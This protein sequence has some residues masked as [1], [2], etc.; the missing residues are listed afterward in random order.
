MAESFDDFELGVSI[1]GA[2]AAIGAS[3]VISALKAIQAAS[4][5][6]ARIMEQEL[7]QKAAAR[8]AASA[9]RVASAQ[10]RAAR[11]AAAA[12]Q[13]SAREQVSAV[14]KAAQEMASATRK[15]AQ[16]QKKAMKEA[17]ASAYSLR[18]AMLAAA[19]G[20][21]AS[22]VVRTIATFESLRATLVTTT[23][24]VEAAGMKFK[25]LQAFAQQTPFSVEEAVRAFNHM[26]AVGLEPTIE[27]MRAFGDAAAMRPDRSFLDFIMAVADGAAGTDKRLRDFGV[28]LKKV[29]DEVKILYGGEVVSTVKN[30]AK[31]IEA[32]LVKLSTQKFGGAMERQNKTLAGQWAQLK[33]K[34]ASLADEMGS[35]GLLAVMKD[36]VEELGSTAGGANSA[37]RELGAT[38]ATAVRLTA[39]AMQLAVKYSTELK[40][41]LG[42]L[43]ANAAVAGL[44]GMA[45]GL[46]KATT[47]LGLTTAA[48]NGTKVAILGLEAITPFGWAVIG[49]AALTELY[50]RWDDVVN[51]ANRSGPAIAKTLSDLQGNAPG[52]SR[53]GKASHQ[54]GVNDMFAQIHAD[55]EARENGT[56]VDAWS[57]A[58][59][60]AE[61]KRKTEQKQAQDAGAKWAKDNAAAFKKGVLGVKKS[62]G[63]SYEDGGLT[64]LASDFGS[65]YIAAATPK[66]KKAPK[67]TDGG[68]GGGKKKEEVDHLAVSLADLA[69]EAVNA[70]SALATVGANP[71][72]IKGLAAQNK[73]LEIQSQLLKSGVEPAKVAAQSEAMLGLITRAVDAEAATD[74][75]KDFTE[76][77]ASLKT[78]ASSAEDVLGLTTRKDKRGVEI[79]TQ[80]G[81]LTKDKN[82]TAEEIAQ[83]REKVAAIVDATTATKNFEDAEKARADASKKSAEKAADAIEKAERASLERRKNMQEEWA[84]FAGS[85]VDSF[86]DALISV[87]D[88]QEHAWRDFF[89]QLAAQAA[90]LALTQTFS[91]GGKGA[92]LFA[93]VFHAG[94]MVGSGGSGRSVSPSVFFGAQRYH[95]GG[96]AG[97]KPDEVPAILQRGE[98]VQSRREVAQGGTRSRSNRN[99]SISISLHGIRDG[100][101]VNDSIPNLLRKL[102][103]LT[104]RDDD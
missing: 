68:A 22:S 9:G 45:T 58:G 54:D 60:A 18:N 88:K 79:S 52:Q 1:D 63:K 24:S 104:R 74:H 3:Q 90:Q 32:A 82:Y 25:E 12:V 30:S 10:A 100:K 33:D 47:A 2:K 15:G 11:E 87:L 85:A 19:T 44:A 27:K 20:T 72:D 35:G 86:G 56:Y 103:Q 37:A 14:K 57:P 75:I 41:V 101:S 96:Y 94:G 61:V 13:K 69:R 64:G 83:L 26:R 55:D 40:L 42:A 91:D 4:V 81:S 62:I 77:L 29:G 16:E 95:T 99:Y 17:E 5:Q 53:E 6:T 46:A 97:L 92:S 67:A 34:A 36:V 70:E 51:I 93:G 80:L 59:A 89:I 23:G 7:E 78:E 48:A 49:I 39:D 76:A 73:L 38:L 31:E 21:V 71:E 65:A 98:R 66:G 102:R 8:I 84:S 50:L 43:A 28:D